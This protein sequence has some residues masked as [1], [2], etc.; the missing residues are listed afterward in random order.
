LVEQILAQRRGS[1]FGD[2]LVLG[3][4]VHLIFGQAA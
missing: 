4:R 2:V 3:E 1:N